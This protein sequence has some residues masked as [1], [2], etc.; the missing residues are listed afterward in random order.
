MARY[1]GPSCRLC[2]RENME[3]YLKGERCFT[4][5]CAIKRRNYAPGQ[6][7]Q[8]RVKVS[9]YGIQ[10]REKQKVR[11]IY[12]ILEKQFRGYFEKA[13]T[14]KGVTGENLLFL[15]EKRL[16]NIVFR[17]GFAT[18]RTQARM[19]VRQGHVTVNG[20]RVDIPSFQV[21]IGDVVSLHEKSRAINSIV[22]SLEAVVRRGIPQWLE[23][24]KDGFCGKIKTLITRDDITTPIQ[25]QLIVELYS[26]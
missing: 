10:L 4:D 22:E 13:D 20:Q 11:R 21:K 5:K 16:D 8:A 15:L 24:D 12:G 1:T 9:P 25:E 18:S 26:K 23:L 19:I 2:R 7:G 14:M 6:H 17:L 3:L